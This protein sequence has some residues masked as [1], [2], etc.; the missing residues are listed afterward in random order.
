MITRLDIQFREI[1]GSLGVYSTTKL[2]SYTLGPKFKRLKEPHPY[3][4]TPVFLVD[5]PD[6]L[7]R[8]L[9]F[10]E[11]ELCYDTVD[12]TTWLALHTGKNA[13]RQGWLVQIPIEEFPDFIV[14]HGYVAVGAERVKVFTH[15]EDIW[16]I[17][18]PG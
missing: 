18:Y 11:V 13:D 6:E 14:I 3:R 12:N 9:K 8:R 17:L 10:T 1:S 4:S 2:C 7:A 5:P 15:P 16:P